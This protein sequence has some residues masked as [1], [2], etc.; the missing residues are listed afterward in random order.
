MKG[1]IKGQH[2]QGDV[3]VQEIKAPKE[4]DFKRI[5]PENGRVVLAYGE[6]TGH[7]HSLD[8]ARVELFE[9]PGGRRYLRML[10]PSAL[11]HQEHGPH[12]LRGT[13]WHEVI[14]QREYA[15]EAIHNVED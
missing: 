6:V 5:D 9:A 1:I 7:S 15:P 2:R 11:E 12:T 13:T 10:A 14:R 4:L 3:L 8:A